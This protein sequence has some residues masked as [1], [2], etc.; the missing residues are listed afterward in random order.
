MVWVL[1]AT[2]SGVEEGAPEIVVVTRALIAR[3]VTAHTPSRL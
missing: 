2:D 1:K 3:A